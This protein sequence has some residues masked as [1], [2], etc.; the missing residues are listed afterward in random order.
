MPP[1]FCLQEGDVAINMLLAVRTILFQLD[2]IFIV[3]GFVAAIVQGDC[4]NYGL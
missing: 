3:H 1:S 4:N 2:A